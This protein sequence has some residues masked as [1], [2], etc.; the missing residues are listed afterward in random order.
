MKGW[1]F[2]SDILAVRPG[3]SGT[4][5]W[6]LLQSDETNIE[7]SDRYP[8]DV[9]PSIGSYQ[10]PFGEVAAEL[11]IEWMYGLSVS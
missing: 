8:A 9:K 2:L 11:Q 7:G 3:L 6:L 1:Y 10:R 4:F 5:H